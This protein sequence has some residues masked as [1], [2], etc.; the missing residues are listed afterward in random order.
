MSDARKK[1]P[2]GLFGSH[3]FEPRYDRGA[4]DMSAFKTFQARDPSYMEALRKQT[5]VCDVCV[6]C[7]ERIGRDAVAEP[8]VLRN[9]KISGL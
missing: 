7:G 4:A 1:C 6:K 3:K 5:Y 2:N 9:L 8:T